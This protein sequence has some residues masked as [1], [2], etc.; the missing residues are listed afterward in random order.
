VAISGVRAGGAGA[1]ALIC[2]AQFVLQLDFSIVNVALPAML[3][4]LQLPAAQ[5]QWIA[6]GYALT[7]GSLLLVGGRLADLVGRRFLF[8]AGL[9]LFAVASVACGLAHSATML[10][11]S[12]MVQGAAGAA[13]A[14]AA[15]SQLTTMYEEGPERNRALGVWQAMTA[16]GAMAGIIVGGLLTQYLGWRSI[17]LINPPLVAAMLVLTPRL[18]KRDTGSRDVHI[19]L[20]GA[21]LLTGAL[22]AL[23][24][25]LSNGEQYGFGSRL[26]I[27]A[28]G[29]AVLLA[30]GF[31]VVER[32]VTEPML[33]RGI[34]S[35]PVRGAAIGA[36][37]LMGAIIAAYVYFVSLYLQNVQGFSA[38][39]TG[40][41]LVP[42]TVMVVVT[43]TFVT[44]RM[45]AWIGMQPVLLVGLTSLAIGQIWLMQIG[46]GG[47]YPAVVLPGL[48]L[49]A[50]GMG[51]ALPTA[52]IAITS[53]VAPQNQGIAGALFVTSQQV[54]GAVGLAVLATVAAART[55]HAHGSLESGY[56]LSFTVA[57]GLA[58][59]AVA[60]V[61]LRFNARTGAKINA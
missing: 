7:F 5:L 13:V 4:D 2:T 49:S 14:P 20:P 34:L 50:F 40:L 8:G 59:V 35:A 19:D 24:F 21:A 52:S 56:G 55:E 10:I 43:S 39:T 51:L 33:P 41:A 15:L 26:T 27:A 9:L 28:L 38:A 29:A 23:I 32:A 12:R 44:R 57:A 30:I 18:L 53:G 60:I 6:T 54:G 42:S 11:V 45:L 36:M 22:G 46:S 17:F 58:F 1:L 31:V 48:L 25:G 37:L 61:A 3:R 47:G 16:A